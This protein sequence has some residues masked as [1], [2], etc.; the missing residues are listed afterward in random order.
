MSKKKTV[1]TP[2][3]AN[4][5]LLV[6]RVPQKPDY[7][8]IKIRRRLESIGA[9]AVKN[10]VYILPLSDP[11]LEDFQWTKREIES[12]GGDASICQARFVEGLNDS[13]IRSFFNSA[14]A[15]DYRSLAEEARQV[16]EAI[17]DAPAAEEDRA[18]LKTEAARLRRKLAAIETIDFFKEPSR[19]EV[20]DMI[21]KMEAGARDIVASPEASSVAENLDPRRLRGRT[22]VTRK[23]VHVDRIASAWLI[24]RFI[25]PAA[26]FK[27][28][29]EKAH[30]PRRG[31]IRFDMFEGEFTH[32]GDRCT[33]EVLA[34]RAG[35][36]A[37]GVQTIGRIVHD[38]DLKDAKYGLAETAGIAAAIG[39]ICSAEEKDQSRLERG[40]Q[41][42][43]ELLA[44]FGTQPPAR[45]KP[46]A[47]GK[48]AARSKR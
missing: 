12:V 6:H 1:A 2:P 10:S 41:L 39:G 34:A 32:E 46:A 25:D 44:H 15:Q 19:K 27:F 20:E 18:R 9:V 3:D 16:A 13:Q 11:S 23:N 29:D 48:A 28:V 33:F 37:P 42:F 35:I 30:K 21:A 26:K 47:R 43:D 4:W 36:D 17:K 7:L 40:A 31:E 14:R 38:I 8:R 45:R 22:W 5:L 24:R